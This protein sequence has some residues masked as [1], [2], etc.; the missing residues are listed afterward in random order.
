MGDPGLLECDQ[1]TRLIELQNILGRKLYRG[2]MDFRVASQY[3]PSLLALLEVCW[4][5]PIVEAEDASGVSFGP[6]FLPLKTLAN[7]KTG[8]TFSLSLGDKEA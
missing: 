6:I 5:G 1:A 2:V 7:P 4:R 8:G 3:N